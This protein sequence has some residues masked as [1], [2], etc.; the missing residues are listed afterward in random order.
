MTLRQ[1][2]VTASAADLA[3]GGEIGDYIALLKPRVMSLVIFTALVGMLC[4]PVTPHPVLALASLLAIAVGAGAAGALNMWY[5]ADIDRIMS[6]TRSRPIPAG[7][8]SPEEAFSFGLT[9]SIGSVL[10]LGLAANWL[11][12]GLLAFTIFF[13]AVVYTAWL[14]RRTPQNIVIGG[15]SGSLPP[16]IAWTAVTGS[17]S[18]APV[19]L[20]AIIFMWTPP[21]FWA[22]ALVRS[23]DYERAGVPMLPV[24]AGRAETRRQILLYSLA[25]VPLGIVPAGIGLGGAFYLAVSVALGT[26]FLWLAV[27]LA[28]GGEDG[29]GPVA[30]R[31]FAFSI[32]YLFGLFAALLV[33]R[34]AGL[35]SLI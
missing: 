27:R 8:V 16:L 31:L 6:R 9:L 2:D 35:P 22:L 23:G 18:L 10:V 7:L 28:R 13:Y 12:A 15:L 11:A 24:V 19:V 25:L 29:V 32:L 21:H 33:E 26:V 1:L 4:A 17:I 30:K 34:V 14:K 20:V 3:R 5:D